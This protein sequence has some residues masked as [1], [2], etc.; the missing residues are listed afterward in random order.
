MGTNL[1]RSRNIKPGFFRN[2]DLVE[3]PF[4]ARLLFIGLW[5]IADRDGRLE[6]RPKQI[7]MELFPADNMDCDSLL[8]QLASINMIERYEH[9]GQ[10]LIQVVNFSKHQNPHKDERPSM[11][12]DCSGHVA[13]QEQRPKKHRAST[14]Q[15]PCNQDASTMAIGL[16]PDSLNLIPDSLNLI[17]DSKTDGTIVPVASAPKKSKQALGVDFLVSKG[18]DPAHAEDWLKAR[19]A[20]KAP[21]T[22]TAWDELCSEARKA[23]I[24]PPEAVRIAAARSWQ[25]FRADW[26]KPSDRAQTTSQ[27]TADRNAEARRLLGFNNPDEPETFDA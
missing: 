23:G 11:L 10:R 27:S 18:C 5:T 3:L 4:E 13:E 14:M 1:A 6:D 15:A 21:L 16:I 8:A 20:K 22:S 12:P 17:P 24:D 25:G 2:A 19:K 9:D 7:K 26:V